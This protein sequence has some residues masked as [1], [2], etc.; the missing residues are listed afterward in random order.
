MNPIYIT[1]TYL[2]QFISSAIQEDIGEGDHSTLSTIPESL[3]GFAQLKI[4]EQ[5]IMAGLFIAK[6]IFFKIDPSLEMKTFLKDGDPVKPGDIAFEVT[7][8]VQSILMAERLVLNC[9]QRMSGIAT[10]TNK[11]CKIIEGTKTKILDTRKTTPNLRPLEK[12][13]V[14]IGGGTNHRFGLFDMIMLKDN[15]VDYSGGIRQ[16]LE[17]TRKYLEKTGKKLRIEIETRSIDEVQQ[18]LD[19]GGADVIMLDNMTVEEMKEAVELIDGKCQTEASGGITE[20]GLLEIAHTGVDFIS[21]GALT[22]SVKS[23]DM[24]LKAVFKK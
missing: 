20:K 9:M 21:I 1:D 11:L 14:R 6:M 15:H 16:A 23:L 2:E 24:S 5:G 18:V 7:G 22:H 13:A 3:N 19:A 17:S 10:Y 12:W 4:K 8:P